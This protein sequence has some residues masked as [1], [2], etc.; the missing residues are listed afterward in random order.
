M[1]EQGTLESLQETTKSGLLLKKHIEK[2][3]GICEIR[4]PTNIVN[5]F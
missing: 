2:V 1:Q 4:H 5:C 3:Q